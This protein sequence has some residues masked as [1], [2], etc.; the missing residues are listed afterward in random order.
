MGSDESDINDFEFIPDGDNQPIFISFD[1]EIHPIV[2]EDA[3]IVV[4]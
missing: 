1:V 2:P 3:G 4:L